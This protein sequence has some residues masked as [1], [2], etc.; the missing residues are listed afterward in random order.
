[1]FLRML[2]TAAAFLP[3]FG[4][5]F[6]HGPE[7]DGP[8]NFK[9]FSLSNPH[10]FNGMLN[11]TSLILMVTSQNIIHGRSM[12]IAFLRISTFLVGGFNPSGKYWSNWII[13][14]GRCEHK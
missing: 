2:A 9:V 10:K 12:E 7:N 1:M 13:S 8:Q 3:G 14:S 11:C 4:S 5:E 6:G